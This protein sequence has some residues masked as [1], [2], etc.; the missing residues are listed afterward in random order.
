MNIKRNVFRICEGMEVKTIKHLHPNIL[1]FEI[2]YY[3]KILPLH[4]TCL[5]VIKL[6][7]PIQCDIDLECGEGLL[8]VLQTI[9]GLWTMSLGIPASENRETTLLT[10]RCAYCRSPIYW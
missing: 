1:H 4:I 6:L 9:G 10:T 7:T 3:M 2:N 8:E 5:F